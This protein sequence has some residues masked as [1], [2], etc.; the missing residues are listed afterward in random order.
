MLTRQ[1][2]IWNSPM[3]SSEII[4]Q[5]NALIE[6]DLRSSRT[7]EKRIAGS[8]SII[9][10]IIEIVALNYLD[11]MIFLFSGAHVVSFNCSWPILVIKDSDNEGVAENANT[12]ILSIISMKSC[13]FN[14]R[15]KEK[16][17]NFGL[18]IYLRGAWYD[19]ISIQTLPILLAYLPR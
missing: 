3:H 6:V 15:W 9:R 16:A 1:R 10:T 4:F 2:T 17:F 18:F 13:T 12:R 7:E 11:I 8:S 14:E 19:L 5:M